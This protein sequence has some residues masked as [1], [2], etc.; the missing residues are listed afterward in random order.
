MK[1]LSVGSPGFRLEGGIPYS[2]TFDDVYYSRDGGID[3]TRHVFL[4]GSALPARWRGCARF[5]IG[6]LG[7]GAGLNLLVTWQAWE[8]ARPAQARLNYVAI[9]GYPLD[10]EELSAAL[11]PHTALRSHA[12]SLLRV[13]PDRAPGFHR[14]HLGDGLTLTLIFGDVADVLPQLHA[15]IDAWY[16]DGFAPNRNPAMWSLEVMRQVARF[17]TDQGSVATYSV[18]SDVRRALERAGFKVTKRAGFGAKREMSCARLRETVRMQDARPWYRPPEAIRHAER[19]VA[20]IG[21]GIAGA[22]TANALARRGWQVVV[23]DFETTSAAEASGNPAGVL[24]PQLTADHDPASRISLAAYLLALRELDELHLRGQPFDWEQCGVIRLGQTCQESARQARIVEA[25]RLPDSLLRRIDAAE[26]SALAGVEL[27]RGGLFFRGAGWVSPRSLCERLIEDVGETVEIHFGARVTRLEHDG[28]SWCTLDPSGRILSKATT[29]VIASGIGS[30]DIEP[31]TWLPLIPVRGQLT[32]TQAVPASE[33][34]ASVLCYDGY[35]LPA[36]DGRHVIGASFEPNNRHREVTVEDHL[37]NRTRLAAALPAL[38]PLAEA[39]PL[40]GWAAIRAATPDHLPLVGGVIDADRFRRDYADLSKGRR[41][42]AYP[43]AQY[44]PGLYVSTGHGSHGLTTAFLAA[45][46]IAGL[47]DG[48]PLPLE[49]DLVDRLN[50][51]RFVVRAL[52]RGR[53]A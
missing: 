34:L 18:A 16:L 25:A 9:E 44:L 11:A 6:E 52:R 45:E 10:R 53:S 43:A 49:R 29:V 51:S 23:L 8:R 4:D 41:A 26:A 22:T 17:T 24:I 13:Y 27:D 36:I 32:L 30:M 5:T 12:R 14:L 35:V 20:V 42:G 37:D 19:T 46:L 50:P 40:A 2:R 33:S 31:L 39:E 3:E 1:P 28:D 38:G 48:E 7:F 21:A 15:S 47:T